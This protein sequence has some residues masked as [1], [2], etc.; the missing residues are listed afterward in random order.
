MAGPIASLLADDAERRRRERADNARLDAYTWDA[1][2]QR[3]LAVYEQLT[4]G[5]A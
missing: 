5:A 1:M 2:A 3:Q 4:Q